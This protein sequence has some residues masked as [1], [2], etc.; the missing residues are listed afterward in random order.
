M[1]A[2]LGG[3]LKYYLSPRW[4]VR[5][6][7]R[8]YLSQNAIDN[9]IDTSNAVALGTPAGSVASATI[10]AIQFSNSPS[11]GIQS[12]LSAPTLNGFRVFEGGG[13]QRQLSTTAGLIWRF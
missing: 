9:L 11:T 4:G 12:S 6:D 8:W 2:V 1:V 7:A 13:I 10:P 5:V 3:G